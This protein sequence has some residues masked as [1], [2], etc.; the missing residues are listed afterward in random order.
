MSQEADRKL[1]LQLVAAE[2][3]PDSVVLDD[4]IRLIRQALIT[5]PVNSPQLAV[6]LSFRKPDLDE[7]REHASLEATIKHRIEQASEHS[8][9][10][11]EARAQLASQPDSA[12][13]LA[14]QSRKAAERVIAAVQRA[15]LRGVKVTIPD[16]PPLPDASK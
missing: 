12:D 9:P 13:K 15:I 2:L 16:D 3:P 1:F 14:E 5:A 7:K 11:V 6:P 4:L 8:R 10:M